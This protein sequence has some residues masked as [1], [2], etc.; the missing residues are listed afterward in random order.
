MDSVRTLKRL[1]SQ[2][3]YNKDLQNFYEPNS[4]LDKLN[5]STLKVPDLT[6]IHTTP[7]RVGTEQ[8]GNRLQKLRSAI[9]M[10]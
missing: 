2:K 5:S 7:N 1:S 10:P 4:T 6:T 3:A 8:R 9:K